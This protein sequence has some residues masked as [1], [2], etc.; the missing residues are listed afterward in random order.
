M[1]IGPDSAKKGILLFILIAIAVVDFIACMNNA[2]EAKINGALVAL[3]IV[4]Y[5]FYLYRKWNK[6]SAKKYKKQ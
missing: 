6:E 3:G 5:A 2:V 1:I 4:G